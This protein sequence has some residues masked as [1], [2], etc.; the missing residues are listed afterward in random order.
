MKDRTACLLLGSRHRESH[1]VLLGIMILIAGLSTSGAYGQAP[2]PVPACPYT[3]LLAAI[4]R[5]RL[6]LEWK[7]AEVLRK[8]TARSSATW[9]PT[10]PLVSVLNPLS[11]EPIG[12]DQF[13]AENKSL[14]G[15]QFRLDKDQSLEEAI[16]RGSD[17]T[18]STFDRTNLT[19]A[20]FDGFQTREAAV[21]QTILRDAKFEGADLTGAVFSG[22]DMT[23]VTFEPE[24]IPDPDG[25]ADARYLDLM[26]YN[27]NP[28]P[29]IKLRQAFRDG[30]FVEQDRRVNYAIH[31]RMATLKYMQ[32]TAHSDPSD[33]KL[34]AC[35][36]YIGYSIADWTCQYGM[37]LWRPIQLGSVA[38]LAFA[39][40]YFI[41]MHDPGP[42]GLYF[43][44]AKGFVLDQDEDKNAQQLRSRSLSAALQQKQ[45]YQWL[46]HEWKLLKGSIFFSLINGFNLGFKEAD[47]GRWLHMLPGREFQ[48]YTLGWSRTFAG[49]QALFTLYLVAIWVLCMFG[50][51]FG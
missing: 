33:H 11:A 21:K 47:I 38:W 30:G 50:H 44:W 4:E 34:G 27:E 19:N 40:V 13:A 18:G 2:S 12:A 42:S 5:H 3:T 17:L 8:D 36:S 49:I 15:C 6:Y 37:N 16:F 35:V 45:I 28:S 32:C 14:E 23:G 24:K 46:C 51:P 43:T 9:Y 25:M 31:R 7:K 26:K 22:A 48:F 41:F 1:A 29:L 20:S 39:G 10:A